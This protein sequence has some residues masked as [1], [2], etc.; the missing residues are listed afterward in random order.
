MQRRHSV[1]DQ[2]QQPGAQPPAKP[3]ASKQAVDIAALTAAVER[4]LRRDL[5]I[6]RE[7]LRGGRTR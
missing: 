4:L 1:D 5:A 2:N 7:R 6:E 3:P